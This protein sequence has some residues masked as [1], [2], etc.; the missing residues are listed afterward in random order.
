VDT[1]SD[2]GGEEGLKRRIEEDIHTRQFLD[3]EW[4]QAEA[5]YRDP[6][7]PIALFPN[8]QDIIMGRN[9]TV[10][11]TWSGNILYHKVIQQHVHRY[12][13]AQDMG[14]NRIEK[15]L[16]SIKI[17]HLLQNE[18][19]SR[20]LNRED[21]RWVVIDNSEAQVK[22][23]QTLRMLAREIVTRSRNG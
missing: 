23:S 2:G 9:K 5:P 10:A 14:S 21:T 3:D 15:T 11:P 12:V 16:I 6:L 8:P 4:R 20:F 1:S 19:K 7:S 17:L 13:E 18:Y 22:I